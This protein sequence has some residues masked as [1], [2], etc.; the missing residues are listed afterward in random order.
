MVPLKHIL[1]LNAHATPKSGTS[2]TLSSCGTYQAP[3]NNIF[4]STWCLKNI[5]LLNI[6]YVIP[7]PNTIM[8]TN[9]SLGACIRNTT[10]HITIQIV[11][12]CFDIF[13]NEE[14]NKL[15]KQGTLGQIVQRNPFRL[16][17]NC[18]YHTSLGPCCLYMLHL[19][20]YKL[21]F[22]EPYVHPAPLQLCI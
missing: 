7:S 10:Y 6:I 19:C 11:R 12:A 21:I 17:K 8:Q 15:A 2:C 20:I 9:S 22:R 13:G 16:T 4:L 18:M 3:P 14:A 1:Q 5:F